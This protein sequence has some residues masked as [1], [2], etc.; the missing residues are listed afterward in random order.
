M[1]IFLE[2]SGFLDYLCWTLEA[3]EKMNIKST[4]KKITRDNLKAFLV[5]IIAEKHGITVRSVYRILDGDRDNPIV[6]D[7]YMILR[8]EYE[9]QQAI[10]QNSPLL[11]EVNNTVPFK[12]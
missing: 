9:Q 6:F 5:K 7:D 8:E 11:N 1:S 3:T 4:D 12:G 2:L 10:Y